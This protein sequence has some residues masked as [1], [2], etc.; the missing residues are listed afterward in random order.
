M[1]SGFL[2]RGNWVGIGTGDFY[3]YNDI[4]LIGTILMVSVAC[5]A[6]QRLFG[7]CPMESSFMLYRTHKCF[8]ELY[9]KP[10]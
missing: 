10:F 7:Y 2:Y 5:I 1:Q 9:G 8:A 3:S 6:T 4:I